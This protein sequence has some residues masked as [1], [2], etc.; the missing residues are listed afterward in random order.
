MERQ[1]KKI[2]ILNTLVQQ[3]EC[4]EQNISPYLKI[5]RIPRSNKLLFNDIDYKYE[6]KDPFKINKIQK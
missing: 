4:L 2:L 3:V 1:R 5:K 6:Y